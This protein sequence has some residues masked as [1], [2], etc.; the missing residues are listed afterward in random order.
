MRRAILPIALLTAPVLTLAAQIVSPAVGQ[1]V[2]LRTATTSPWLVGTL[3]AVDA[4]TLRLRVADSAPVVSVARA[5][6]GRL[7]VSGGR[8]S[9]AGRGAVY[10]AAVLGGLGLLAGVACANSDTYTWVRC[11]GG[12][13]A[14]LTVWGAA[15]GAGFGA[16]IGAMSHRE[17]WQ[18]AGVDHARVS[19]GPRGVGVGVSLTF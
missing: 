9:N 16:L 5:T 2:R 3:V 8:H 7:D 15:F 17:D 18:S 14:A 12:D 6:I 10:G 4:D 11:D 1:R 13:V 19:L